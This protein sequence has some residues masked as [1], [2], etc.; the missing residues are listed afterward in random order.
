MVKIY[1]TEEG[2]GRVFFGKEIIDIKT[3]SQTF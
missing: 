2:R 3:F 1:R